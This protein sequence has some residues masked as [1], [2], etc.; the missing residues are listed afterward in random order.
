MFHPS[1]EDE[2]P[3]PADAPHHR[4]RDQQAGPGLLPGLGEVDPVRHAEGASGLNADAMVDAPFGIRGPDGAQ[5]RELGEEAGDIGVQFRIPDAPSAHLA[6]H[7]APKG[8]E[9]Q[10]DPLEIPRQLAI[11]HLGQVLGGPGGIILCAMEVPPQDR[12]GEG[13]HQ[14]VHQ[15]EDGDDHPDPPGRMVRRSRC[16]RRKR[17]EASL[18]QRPGVAGPQPCIQVIDGRPNFFRSLATIKEV[19]PAWTPGP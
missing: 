1:S 14:E 9:G 6:G 19:R 5:L 13:Q 4:L 7:L 12:H 15:E 3:L 8:E 11:Q 18:V 10:V 17:Q 16:H 2:H